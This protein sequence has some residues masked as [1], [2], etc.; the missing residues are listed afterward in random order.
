[1]PTTKNTTA[2]TMAMP[3]TNMTK[4]ALYTGSEIRR[5]SHSKTLTFP[6]R[7]GSR[8]RIRRL[9]KPQFD[10]EQGHQNMRLQEGGDCRTDQGVVTGAHD[11]CIDVIS[12]DPGVHKMVRRYSLPQPSPLTIRVELNNYAKV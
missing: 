6:L 2:N 9:S 12:N 11:D 7:E 1:M 8:F 3:D 4:R 10:L 5:I